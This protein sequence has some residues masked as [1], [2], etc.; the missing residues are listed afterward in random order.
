MERA[1]DGLY[2]HYPGQEEVSALLVLLAHAQVTLQ[3]WTNFGR[4]EGLARDF[5]F[6]PWR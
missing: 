6:S 5:V 4:E 3:V 2:F 1:R